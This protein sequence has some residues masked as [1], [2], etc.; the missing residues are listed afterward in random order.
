MPTK[1]AV[2]IG[3]SEAV[4]GTDAVSTDE[5]RSSSPGSAILQRLLSKKTPSSPSKGASRSGGDAFT[6]S[7]ANIA[8][9]HKVTPSTVDDNSEL[10]HR[11]MVF[12]PSINFVRFINFQKLLSLST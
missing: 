2:E 4:V 10:K 1:I 9:E 3:G 7:E 5:H 8:E 12:L 11:L 6:E